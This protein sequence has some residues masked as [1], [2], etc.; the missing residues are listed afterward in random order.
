MYC[1]EAAGGGVEQ[2]DWWKRLKERVGEGKGFGKHGKE[3][4]KQFTVVVVVG[5]ECSL[6]KQQSLPT[7]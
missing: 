6:I 7:F 1:F 3:I 2:G 4:E 5:A